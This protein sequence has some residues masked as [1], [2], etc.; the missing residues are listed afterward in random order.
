[1][2]WF[3]EYYKKKLRDW[4]EQDIKRINQYSKT[5]KRLEKEEQ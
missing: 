3:K 4:I 1:M 5:L 2:S